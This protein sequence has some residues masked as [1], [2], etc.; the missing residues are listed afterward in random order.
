MVSGGRSAHQDQLRPVCPS[1]IHREERRSLLGDD[2]ET[3]IASVDGE[4]DLAG[5]AGF[6]TTAGHGYGKRAPAAA[7]ARELWESYTQ[8]AIVV[9]RQDTSAAVGYLSKATNCLHQA[10]RQV[11]LPSALQVMAQVLEQELSSVPP[12]ETFVVSSFLPCVSCI[13]SFRL[14]IGRRPPQCMTP[15][16]YGCGRGP[17]GR[18][19]RA[20]GLT[21]QP[22]E[23]V[24]S[25]PP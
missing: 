22:P 19:R 4:F 14:S 8:H 1:L 23:R 6:N 7:D 2:E 18:K 21:L 24:S 10:N 20:A 25:S 16:L 3:L 15:D 13:C 17:L 9:A 12:A 11:W 5:H